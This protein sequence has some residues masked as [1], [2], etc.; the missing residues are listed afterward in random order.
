MMIYLPDRKIRKTYSENNGMMSLNEN[1]LFVESVDIPSKDD[2]V[3]VSEYLNTFNRDLRGVKLNFVA[4]DVECVA[5]LK[6]ADDSINCIYI[7]YEDLSDYFMKT[8]YNSKVKYG[9]ITVSPVFGTNNPVV[10]PGIS[11]K[12]SETDPDANIW[13]SD[14]YRHSFAIPPFNETQVELIESGTSITAG[15]GYTATSFYDWLDDAGDS[16]I[17]IVKLECKDVVTNA[18]SITENSEAIC[19]L[20]YPH[21]DGAH[22]DTIF[23]NYGVVRGNDIVSL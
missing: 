9:M 2:G 11:V 5:V 4:F 8:N 12:I 7:R 6:D 17:D 13:S 15:A 18:G 1:S 3:F 20:A 23:S 14:A 16:L 22:N 21:F 19:H 10:S